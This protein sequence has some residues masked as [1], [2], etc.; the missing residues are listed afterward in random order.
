MPATEHGAEHS[1]H[2]NFR[3]GPVCAVHHC[4][5]WQCS[6]S[7]AT[8]IAMECRALSSDSGLWTSIDR[9]RVTFQCKRAT[10]A[11]PTSEVR[12]L[13]VSDPKSTH[14]VLDPAQRMSIYEYAVGWSF[15]EFRKQTTISVQRGKLGENYKEVTG[16][17]ETSLNFRNGKQPLG[18]GGFAFASSC[19]QQTGR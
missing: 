11:Q 10:F 9:G 19:N 5:L 12:W 8:D 18:S 7:T 3:Q 6:G 17:R 13:I 15:C 16:L 14:K 2:S 1:S 4:A